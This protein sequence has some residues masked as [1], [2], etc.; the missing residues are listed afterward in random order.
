MIAED[1]RVRYVYGDGREYRGYYRRKPSINY[2]PIVLFA[3]PDGRTQ[4][5]T[6]KVYASTSFASIGEH[7]SVYYKPDSPQ[8]AVIGTF[9]EVWGPVLAWG[10]GSLVFGLA[11]YA[12]RALGK[13]QPGNYG[14]D[15]GDE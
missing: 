7:V 14:G 6:G 1:R 10:G 2:A 12:G 13:A 15:D 9:A 3:L 11:W 4:T 5:I 8:D